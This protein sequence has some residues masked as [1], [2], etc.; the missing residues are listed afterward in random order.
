MG[1]F[2]HNVYI[3]DHKMRDVIVPI[4]GHKTGEGVVNIVGN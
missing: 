3:V 1:H 4:V 2:V